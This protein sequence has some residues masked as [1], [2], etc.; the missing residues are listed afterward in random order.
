MK[1][2]ASLQTQTF[3]F[4]IGREKKSLRLQQSYR[5][6]CMQKVNSNE[7]LTNLQHI[8]GYITK[9]KRMQRKMN[10]T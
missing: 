10:T 8:L 2:I 7:L 9:P 5:Q 1:S 6:T 4:W 3:F